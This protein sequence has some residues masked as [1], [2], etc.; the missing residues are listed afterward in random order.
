ME[1]HLGEVVHAHR[2]EP[3]PEV[4]VCGLSLVA[5]VLVECSAAAVELGCLRLEA[6]HDLLEIWEEALRKVAVL[7][8]NP[9]L[10]LPELRDHGLGFLALPLAEGDGDDPPLF[11][12]AKLL[13]LV[14][15]V[16]AG[17]QEKEERCVGRTTLVDLSQVVDNRGD[18]EAAEGLLDIAANGHSRQLGLQA[19]NQRDPSEVGQRGLVWFRQLLEGR[20]RLI[21][22]HEPL[23]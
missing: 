15:R 3:D 6:L 22:A 5:Q 11:L 13:D 9:A 20:L 21:A 10:G 2:G 17:G 14:H 8:D 19:A 7:Q 4:G 1:Q 23:P 18:E 12:L 16:I